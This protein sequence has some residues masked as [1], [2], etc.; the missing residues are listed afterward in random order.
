MGEEE[1]EGR[2]KAPF[3]PTTLHVERGIIQMRH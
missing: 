1:E 2:K 3:I